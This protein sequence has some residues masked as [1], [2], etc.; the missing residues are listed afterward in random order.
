[1]IALRRAGERVEVLAVLGAAVAALAIGYGTA[2]YGPK[3]VGAGVVGAGVLAA[4]LIR[5]ELAYA[6]L[7]VVALIAPAVIGYGA[8]TPV[9]LL[10]IGIV[11]LRELLKGRLIPLWA[12]LLAY[13]AAYVLIAIHG[14]YNAALPQ[15]LLKYLLPVALALATAAAAA[16]P[17]VRRRLLMLLGAAI[18]VQVVV[19][20]SQAVQGIGTYGRSNFEQFGDFVTGTLG[21]SASGLLTLISVALA[22]VVFAMALERVW[23][24]RVLMVVAFLLAGIG[25]ISV[26]RA[27]FVFV[28]AAFGAVLLAGGFFARRSLGLRRVVT[29]GT[30][31][32]ALTPGLVF[33][34]S[35][36][37]PGVTQ[38]IN[39]VGKLRD[40]LFLNTA[41]SGPTPERGAQLELSLGEFKRYDLGDGLLGRGAG[42]TWLESEPHFDSS[43]DYPIVLAPQEFANSVWVPRVLLEGGLL[44]VLAFAG[45]L[46]AL[47]NLARR[48]RPRMPAG[49]LDSAIM[50]AM[51]GL[52]AL[53][54]VA[55]FY[56]PVLAS[57]PYAT[58]FWSLAGVSLAISRT[59]AG[60][61]P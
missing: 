10:V 43:T 9:T 6:M 18:A 15:A 51:P 45:L 22:T 1:M 53:T 26:A 46:L 20:A 11:A 32:L 44:G 56:L 16:D 7:F 58:V 13:S 29:V 61:T 49:T 33:A 2:H 41:N 48:A 25:V 12:P 50:L 47:V 59:R 55:A 17:L 35:T 34:M 14:G 28:P 4:S 38:D 40:Y 21:T 36:L 31:L 42:Y 5:V 27:V 37:Y 3:L 57:P 39:S 8:W 54:F 60:E 52:A 19:A 23:R 30:V 24:P